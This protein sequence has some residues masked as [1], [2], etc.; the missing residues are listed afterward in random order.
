MPYLVYQC[1]N[2]QPHRTI[3]IGHRFGITLK[4]FANASFYWL[5]SNDCFELAVSYPFSITISNLPASVSHWIFSSGEVPTSHLFCDRR[6]EFQLCHNFGGSR[7]PPWDCLQCHCGHNG[8]QCYT[9]VHTIY[10]QIHRRWSHACSLHDGFYFHEVVAWLQIL[11]HIATSQ[12]GLLQA[13]LHLWRSLS[14]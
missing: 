3:A 10:V 4:L 5:M 6:C 12:R 11:A 1:D 7:R 8:R 9:W 2:V 13:H 14:G